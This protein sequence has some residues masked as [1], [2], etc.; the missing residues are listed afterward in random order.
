MI[1]NIQLY[2]AGKYICVVDTDVESLSAVAVL[3]VKGKKTSS[4]LCKSL[5]KTAREN[6]ISKIANG[7][8]FHK[9]FLKTKRFNLSLIHPFTGAH[10]GNAQRAT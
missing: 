7:L 5:I 1:R 6:K 3:I 10:T 9:A 8:H 4:Q 2:H